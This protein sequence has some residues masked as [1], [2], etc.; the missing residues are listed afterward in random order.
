[1]QTD[2]TTHQGHGSK[3]RTEACGRRLVSLREDVFVRLSD[4]G[5]F[6]E[7]VSDLVCRLLDEREESA[8]RKQAIRQ[9]KIVVAYRTGEEKKEKEAA[10]R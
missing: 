7:S 2:A 1:M 8:G 10:A 3:K 9:Q 5:R 4:Y 6:G